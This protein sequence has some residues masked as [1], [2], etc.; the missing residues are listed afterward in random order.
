MP[1]L[2]SQVALSLVNTFLQRLFLPNRFV[3][4]AGVVLAVAVT[5][6][7]SEVENLN[8]GG[9]TSYDGWEELLGAFY[10]G[11]G[12]FPGASEW[13][14][15]IVS[16]TDGSG[17][18]RLERLNGG[19]GG[20]PFPAGE[21][22]YF[23]SFQQN[24]NEL[25]GT[26]R[27]ADD[28]PVP[29]VQTVVFQIQIGEAVG[30]DFHRPS[31]APVLKING[32]STSLAPM[33]PE[34]LDRYQN[35]SYF[36]PATQQ[37]EPVYVNTWGFQW[38]VS[39][40]GPITSIQ[41]D[42]SAVTHAQI[43]AMRLDQSSQAYSTSVFDGGGTTDTRV[44]ALSGDLAFGDVVVGQSATRTLTITNNGNS[45]LNVTGISY[46]ST[47]FSGNWTGNIPAGESRNVTVTFQPDA[48]GIA[49]G[50]LTVNSDSTSG[51]NTIPVSGTGLAQTRIIGVS[52]S[53]VFGNVEVGQTAARTM[54]ISNTGN[55]ALN[56]SSISYP[57]G[58]S[59][60]WSGG[61]INPGSSRNVWVTFAPTAAIAYDGT[62]TVNA[63][64]TSG[65]S[66]IN[67]SGAG[68]AGLSGVINLPASLNLGSAP[69]GGTQTAILTI[70]NSGSSPL[71]VNGI[72]YPPGFSGDWIGGPIAAG[73]NR[74]VQVIFSPTRA[75]SFTGTISVSSDAASGGSAVSVSGSGTPPVMLQSTTGAAQ[76][77]GSVTTVTHRFNSTPNTALQIQY[78]DNLADPNSW[79]LHPVTVPSGNGVFDVTFSRSGDHRAAWSR[80]MYF[81]LLYQTQP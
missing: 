44:I 20:G 35:G 5:T 61:N 27:I 54:T 14:A 24:Q 65:T 78:T 22:I 64:P 47:V 72:T 67:A 48:A 13:P 26:L 45:A 39:A 40:L 55:T 1:S 60:S 41:I 9:T 3:L 56:V 71:N 68:V 80:G 32:Q 15:P 16:N 7:R 73:D 31:G 63:N 18:A 53:L 10:P 17:D 30:Y 42:F 69:V 77:N 28:K 51:I 11:Y 19:G 62:I 46:P 12:G 50:N 33:K 74:Q 66:T 58:F 21:S 25:G 76:Y 79:V 43:Y 81:R 29:G 2:P 36:S 6:A 23:G 75:G 49:S 8:L 38:D 34:R 70:G 37:S 4:L 52:G 57:P 59:G